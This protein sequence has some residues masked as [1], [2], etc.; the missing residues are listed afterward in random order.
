MLATSNSNQCQ[1]NHFT[2]IQTFLIICVFQ[3]NGKYDC[4]LQLGASVKPL[5]VRHF[6]SHKM[7]KFSL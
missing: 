6:W 1:V 2:F 3:G 5:N 7:E 4:Q